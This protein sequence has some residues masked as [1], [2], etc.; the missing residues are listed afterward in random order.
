MFRNLAAQAL[1]LSSIDVYAPEQHEQRQSIYT[2][3][4][5]LDFTSGEALSYSAKQLTP[6]GVDQAHLALFM[7]HYFVQGFGLAPEDKGSLLRYYP[8]AMGERYPAH[9]TS[10]DGI[11]LRSHN[12]DIQRLDWLLENQ[13]HEAFAPKEKRTDHDDYDILPAGPGPYGSG[14]LALGEQH[15]HSQNRHDLNDY[16]EDDFPPEAWIETTALAETLTTLTLSLKRDPIALDDFEYLYWWQ[17]KD[18]PERYD[19]LLAKQHAQFNA[20]ATAISDYFKE[21]FGV[22]PRSYYGAHGAWDQFDEQWS[23]NRD[24]LIAVVWDNHVILGY[25]LFERYYY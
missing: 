18:N 8:A 15:Q 5:Q 2:W 6:Q 24:N 10:K 19:R 4:D 23:C 17:R 11:A 12:P 1:H 13:F 3:L 16:G 7:L 22:T 14:F 21:T 25:R 20:G 9:Y